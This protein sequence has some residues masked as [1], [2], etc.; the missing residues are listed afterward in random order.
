MEEILADQAQWEQETR[1]WRRELRNHI[2]DEDQP[3]EVVTP[4]ELMEGSRLRGALRPIAPT[5]FEMAKLTETTNLREQ[6]KKELEEAQVQHRQQLDEQKS[7]LKTR[8]EKALREQKSSLDK[9][10]K[11]AL[12]LQQEEHEVAHTTALTKQKDDLFEEHEH[13]LERQESQLKDDQ[14]RDFQKQKRLFDRARVETLER[15]RQNLNEERNTALE[16][17]KRELDDDYNDALQNQKMQ[18]ERERD[19]ALRTQ[20]MQLDKDR[21][22]ALQNQKMEFERARDRALQTQKEQLERDQGRTLQS[23]KDKLEHDR[24]I[25]LQTQKEP[26]E[27]KRDS[28]LQKQKEQLEQKQQPIFREQLTE[29]VQ[30]MSDTQGDEGASRALQTLFDTTKIEFLRILADGLKKEQVETA[31]KQAADDRNKQKELEEL[32]EDKEAAESALRKEVERND[33]ILQDVF[34]SIKEASQ[35]FGFKLLEEAELSGKI[36]LLATW[37]KSYTSRMYRASFEELSRRLRIPL[38]QWPSFE[39][40]PREHNEQVALLLADQVDSIV[41]ACN[42]RVDAGQR[43]ASKVRVASLNTIVE[44]FEEAGR[45]VTTP[46]AQLTAT[47]KSLEMMR[48]ECAADFGVGKTWDRLV[49]ETK[50]MEKSLAAK[51]KHIEELASLLEKRKKERDERGALL[52]EMIAAAK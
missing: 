42:S 35:Y 37:G 12:Q 47:D 1:P 40:S 45:S 8:Y 32:E 49:A 26:L 15:Q 7:A 17:Q 38:G 3:P 48:D 41:K 13:A 33:D 34:D 52:K 16:D 4:R 25:A 51:D 18:L 36:K 27:S 43:P 31:R 29:T 28:A 6:H 2:F 46:E 11:T 14:E 23:Q 50:K 20:K 10:H 21:G 9:V 22:S 5:I 30:L 24:D 39:V 19:G 44:A